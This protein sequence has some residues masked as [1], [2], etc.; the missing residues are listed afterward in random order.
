MI[1][2]SHVHKSYGDK[3]ILRDVSVRFPQGKVTSLIG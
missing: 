2:L 3:P 1:S